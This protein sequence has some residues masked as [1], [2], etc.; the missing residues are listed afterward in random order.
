MWRKTL[1]A[2]LL[3]LTALYVLDR[4]EDFLPKLR[5]RTVTVRTAWRPECVPEAVRKFKSTGL[6]VVDAY[7]DRDFDP[8]FA[9]IHL[10]ISFIKAETYY[11]LERKIEADPDFDL[12]AARE[13]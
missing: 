13:L 10:R 9:D 4:F 6:R 11:A 8:K 1:L 3:I 12:I 2:T 7:F 5:Y